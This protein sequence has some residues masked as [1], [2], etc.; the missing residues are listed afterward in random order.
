MDVSCEASLCSQSHMG[1]ND[2]GIK[3]GVV[4][5]IVIKRSLTNDIKIPIFSRLSEAVE[6]SF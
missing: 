5:F 6:Y 1:A 3:I 4:F 2:T